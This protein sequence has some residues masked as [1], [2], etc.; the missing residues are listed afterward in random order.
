MSTSTS[1]RPTDTWVRALLPAVAIFFAASIDRNYQTD[2]WH[3]LARGRV[4][5]NEGQLLN[6][7]R[8]TYTV[9]GQTLI[10]VNWGSQVIF[11]HLHQLGGL[12]LLQ[13][14]NALIHA[15]VMF[16]VV[17]HCQR[18][19]QSW[20]IAMGLGLF[21][22]LGLWQLILIRPQTF[23]LLLFVLLYLILEGSERRCWLLI[24]PP[25]IQAMWVNLHGAFPIG[26]VL[27]GCYLFGIFLERVYDK[28]WGVLRDGF[29][30]CLFI[31]LLASTLATFVNPYG[32][33]VIRYVG[34][35]SGRAAARKN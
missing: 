30:W 7:D 22:F 9:H 4:I 13:T 31:C 2:L 33:E 29:V 28:R 21:T 3:H 32:L 24:F 17:W 34:T 27:I 5:V 12:P 16:L 10:D 35:T 6:E 26:L 1:W 19:S 23:S 25:I 8:F 18:R 15:L 14:V 11:Y 20:L